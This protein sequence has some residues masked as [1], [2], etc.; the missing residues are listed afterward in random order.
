MHV[1][2]IAFS[3]VAITSQFLI[4]YALPSNFDDASDLANSP[5]ILPRRPN[6]DAEPWIGMYKD[7][8]CGRNLI[9]RH[10]E[11]PDQSIDH[12]F[13]P[14]PK[15]HRSCQTWRPTT[16]NVTNPSV[17]ISFGGGK[18]EISKVEF[19][20]VP[21][22]SPNGCGGDNHHCCQSGPLLGTVYRNGENS[23]F[24]SLKNKGQLQGACINYNATLWSMA[25]YIGS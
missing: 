16:I 13:K 9:M 18:N 7:E 22:G 15:I 23:A 17:G 24:G 12:E 2:T 10:S 8:N 20:G 5:E 4:S 19:Y 14:R 11:W 3:L 21:A 1:T 25:A 6:P